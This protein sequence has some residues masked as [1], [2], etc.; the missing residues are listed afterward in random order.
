VH[1]TAVE[2]V[3]IR[4]LNEGYRVS[5]K[6]ADDKGGNG[7]QASR[8]KAFNDPVFASGLQTQMTTPGRTIGRRGVRFQS[9]S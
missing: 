7:E 5:F 4:A 3:G 2:A 9:E 8:L 1:A 6:L